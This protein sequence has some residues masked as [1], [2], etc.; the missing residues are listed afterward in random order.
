MITPI[1]TGMME[2]VRLEYVKEQLRV[3][4]M[5]IDIDAI[6]RNVFGT[7]ILEDSVLDLPNEMAVPFG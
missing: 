2:K 5:L 6:P 4:S 1:S 3:Y 7:S